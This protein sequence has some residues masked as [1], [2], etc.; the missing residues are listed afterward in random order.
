MLVSNLEKINPSFLSWGVHFPPQSPGFRKSTTK[1]QTFISPSK[2]FP[3]HKKVTVR[4]T[5]QPHT[6][7]DCRLIAA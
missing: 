2:V 5:N 3:P 4:K 7:T 6:Y 1:S